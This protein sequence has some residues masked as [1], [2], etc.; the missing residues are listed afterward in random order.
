MFLKKEGSDVLNVLLGKIKEVLY[1]VLPITVI[2]LLL[3]FTII[4]MSSDQIW[5]FILGSL[6]IIIGMSIFL[7]GVELFVQPLGNLIGS[8]LAKS[9][10]AGLVGITGLF[11]G[12]FISIAEPA[13]HILAVQVNSI[14][15]EAITFWGLIIAVSLGLAITVSL[16][17]L[18]IV[19][20]VSL[21][22][23]LTILYAL[24]FIFSFFA[25]TEFL[26]IA[27]DSSGATTGAM[28]VPFMLSLSL[29]IASL[30][31]KGEDSSDDSF[32]LVAIASAGAIL[33]VLIMSLFSN[34]T[35]FS[36][37]LPNDV[38]MTS[39]FRP[40]IDLLPQQ[41][42]DVLLSLLPLLV[43]FIIFQFLYFKLPWHG[44]RRFLKGM[45]YTTVG[46]I[47][48]LLGV[49]AGFM[50]VGKEVGSLITALGSDWMI[51]L[52]GFFLGLVIILAEPAV[53]VLTHQIEDVTSGSLGRFSVLIALGLGVGTAVT[54][55]MIRVLVP[56]LELWHYILPGYIIA[57]AMM[58]FVP[59]LFVGIAFDSGGVASGPMIGTFIFAFVQG[60]ATVKGANLITD[61]FG[62]IALVALS[63]LISIQILGLMYRMK[64]RKGGQEHEK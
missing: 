20:N 35:E 27:F 22:V 57:F 24:I 5:R 17:V 32:G 34:A 48:F 37:S 49:N 64:T 21:R 59:K 13:L 15:N 61:G 54:L 19:F 16:G 2:V 4:P 60:V 18:R 28:A 14:T 40:F 42:Y 30:K 52:V 7:F 6:A 55:A 36:G 41:T 50:E 53:Y 51:P 29:G 44:V 11:L 25:P 38:E 3:H 1:S 26:V 23:T 62:M 63:P 39:I 9:N 10:K 47:L 45:V 8:T 56:G 43:V 12:F 33:G 58:P 31:R 46:L